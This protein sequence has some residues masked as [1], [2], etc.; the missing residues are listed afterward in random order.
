MLYGYLA[1]VLLIPKF[2]G[3]VFECFC[4]IMPY[5]VCP[6]EEHVGRFVLRPE[7]A[8][9]WKYLE[10]LLILISTLLKNNTRFLLGPSLAP[11]APLYLGYHWPFYTPL[12]A[13]LWM[14]KMCNWFVVWMGQI[15]FL[16][17]YF[18][19][20]CIATDIPRWFSFLE[21]QGIA[22][23]WLSGLQSST[24]CN[25]SRYVLLMCGS[26]SRLRW[27]WKAWPTPGE[28]VYFFECSSLVPMDRQ[29]SKGSQRETTTCICTFSLPQ[30]SYKLLPQSWSELPLQFCL[31]LFYHL[32]CQIHNIS[33]MNHGIQRTLFLIINSHIREP[34][35]TPQ[36][37]ICLEP[38]SWSHIM[39]TLWQNHGPNSSK[40]VMNKTRKKW[41][42]KHQW[43]VRL[44][45]IAKKSHQLKKLTF[46]SGIGVMKILCSFF[47]PWSPGMRLE[48]SY[49]HTQICI[50][51]TTHTAM[52]GMLVN[53]LGSRATMMTLWSQPL[54]ASLLTI[55]G[56][57][58]KQS[59]KHSCKTEFVNL[60]Q[61]CHQNGSR[62]LFFHILWILVPSSTLPKTPLTYWVTW[63]STM[64]SS[65]LFLCNQS[66][67]GILRTGKQISKIPVLIFAKTLHWLIFLNL[68][69]ASSRDLQ[70]LKKPFQ[71]LATLTCK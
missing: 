13:C 35:T 29:T 20:N 70:W 54:L 51:S 65:P 40:F 31:Q 27:E 8:A 37:L 39:L 43:S 19:N 2:S 42:A 71:C 58:N 38:I 7:K 47:A 53:T 28:V 11:V 3:V 45:L 9:Q 64:V 66:L 48:T 63:H 25:F 56:L 36:H 55:T 30:K 32:L 10:D 4:D 17:G 12:A 50:W 46:F 41:Q 52:S 23:S 16:L 24:V 67:L 59:M 5:N 14:K 21:S 18:K 62:N 69:W 60:M 68:L 1:F 57:W 26:I 22:Q 6:S 33:L 15:S 34:M 44:V 61:C 49:L